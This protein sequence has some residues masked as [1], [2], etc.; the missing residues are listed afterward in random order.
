MSAR[1][2]EACLALLLVVSACGRAGY[3]QVG[4]PIAARDGG[5]G[6][7]CDACVPDGGGVLRDD[8]GARRDG[9][10]P[11]DGG[12]TAV[13]GGGVPVSDGGSGGP[14]DG[15]VVSPDGGLEPGTCW[16]DMDC[17]TSGGMCCPATPCAGICWE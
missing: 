10:R 6:T 4:G 15:A 5:G 14:D 3:D 11:M 9:G 12:G 2:T 17:I 7:D 1:C 8:G 16:R 13:D